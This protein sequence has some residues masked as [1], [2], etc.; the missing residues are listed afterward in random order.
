MF[1]DTHP[2]SHPEHGGHRGGGRGGFRHGGGGGGD[3]GFGRSR[4]L[5]SDDLQLLLLGLLEAGAAHGYELMRRIEAH[6]GGYYSPSPGM[7]YPALAYLDD[8]DEIAAEMDGNRKRY[9]LTPSGAERLGR[10]R[11]RVEA[12]MSRLARI[13]ARMDEVRD[14]FSGL[15]D[16]D[17]A[18][19][20]ELH[21]ARHRLKRALFE[22]RGCSPEEAR[23]IAEALNHATEAI[24]RPTKP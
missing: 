2:H 7:I 9:R 17:P 6:S 22:R 16:Q 19:A 5:G 3:D 12:L 8:A 4:K 13:G 10:N 24:L 20:K 23:R 18:A 11:D 1:Y 15:H 14:A 21:D